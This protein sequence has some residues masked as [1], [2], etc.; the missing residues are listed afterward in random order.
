MTRFRIS[1]LRMFFRSMPVES[2]PFSPRVENAFVEESTYD[3]TIGSD[4]CG[5]DR[6]TQ[7]QSTRGFTLMEMVVAVLIVSIMLAAIMPHLLGAGQR[8][9][10]A[11]CEQNQRTIRAALTEYYMVNHSYP[12]GNTTQQLQ[13]LKSSQILQ[14]VPTEP[15][16]G[17]YIIND[18][19]VNNVVVS[20]S[21]HGELGNDQ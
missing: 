7:L 4:G 5:D 13:L 1:N 17:N 6:T 16:G 14:S 21:E 12:A 10:A 9:E 15:S 2:A 19:D 8:T 3:G 11:A 18:T 20:C